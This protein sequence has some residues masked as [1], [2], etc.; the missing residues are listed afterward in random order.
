MGSHVVDRALRLSLC[1]ICLLLSAC[2][3]TP[4]YSD[5]SEHQANEILAELMRANV[6][7][8]KTRATGNDP[9]WVVSVDVD[10]FDDAMAVLRAAGLP[11]GAKQSLGEIFE[12]EGFVSSALEEKARYI[13]GL[14]QG[15]ESTIMGIDGV[16]DAS[17]HIALPE[18]D[19]LT[20][21]IRPARASV[22]IIKEAN[23][24]IEQQK[25]NIIS[26]VK[27]GIEGLDD[28]ENITVIFFDAHVRPVVAESNR[29]DNRRL[30]T[31][32]VAAGMS[33][34]ALIFAGAIMLRARRAKA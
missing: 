25:A 13:F 1:F 11:N 15:F 3:G 6:A 16:V 8:E 34:L 24:K 23:S 28:V 7:G 22:T 29:Q 32:I 19:L 33:L 9:N 4:L 12:K 2:T 5:L 26:I 14:E 27:N 18:R 30:T 17:V 10:Q 20:N 21:A 31:I